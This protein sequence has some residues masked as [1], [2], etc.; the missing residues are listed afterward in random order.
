MTK[1]TDNNKTIEEIYADVHEVHINTGEQKIFTKRIA[2]K[3]RK[4][5]WLASSIWLLFFFGSYLRWGDRQAVLFDI[6]NRQFHI[7]ELTI[8]PQ[9]FWILALL[10]LF[11]AILLA[12]VTALAGRVYCGFFCFQT[13]WTDIFTLIETKIEGNP[14]QQ[15]KLANASFS[16]KKFYKLSLKYF[17][18]LIISIFTGISFVAWF[19]D[20]YILWSDVF[21]LNL[22]TAS[23]TTI[24]LF[25]VGTFILAGFMREQTCFWLC[26]YARIQA[27]MV[28][29]NSI[30]PSY[31][32]LRG[33]PRGRLKKGDL[34][35]GNGHCIECKQCIALCPTGVDIRAGQ[36]EGCIMCALC[37]DA[38]DEIM[39]KIGKPTG[40]IKYD[41]WEGIMGHDEV[42]ILKRAR[43]WVYNLVLLLSIFGIIYGL[44]SQ[45]ALELK[46]LHARQSLYVLQSDGSSQNRYTLKILNKKTKD[47]YVDVRVDS[48]IL[49]D[50]KI[51]GEIKNIKAEAGRVTSTTVFVSTDKKNLTQK[52][53]D[54]KFSIIEVN[55]KKI[56]TEMMKSF[57]KSIFLG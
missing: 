54:I 5:K 53:T 47:I 11:F 32:V 2:G 35:E 36:Q 46:V 12:V 24:A 8:L 29:K 41:S 55:T 38:C 19:Y 56:A 21:L 17:L 30:V 18:W 23:F 20:V 28:D 57:R 15:K 52:Y 3:F 39:Q 6:P 50:L 48:D 45:D 25:T 1:I 49:K 10:L 16:F 40:L 33:E 27:V 44:S 14:S 7:F 37:I 22:G 42:P 51:K 26:P 4:L 43:F 13:I 9:D 31:D 34:V